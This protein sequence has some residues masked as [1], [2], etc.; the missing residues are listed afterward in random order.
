MWE[1]NVFEAADEAVA[2][3]DTADSGGN[4]LKT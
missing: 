2:A 1:A 4:E 3:A